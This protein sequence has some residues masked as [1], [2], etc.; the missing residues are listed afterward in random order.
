MGKGWSLLQQVDALT[1]GVR[2][3]AED[4]VQTPCQVLG[5]G[6]GRAVRVPGEQRVADRQVLPDGDLHPLQVQ[7][8]EVAQ[9]L[10]VRPQLGDDPPQV[11]V[12]GRA[13]DRP[14]EAVGQLVERPGPRR[15]RFLVEGAGERL[16]H[17]G[18]LLVQVGVGGG[19]LGGLP[20]G[21]W[22]QQRAELEQVAHAAG[23]H[24]RDPRP[25]PRHQV[26]QALGGQ[27][28]QRLPHRRARGARAGHEG[29]LRQ[30]RAGGQLAELDLRP[31]LPVHHVGLAGLLRER[32][33]RHARAP[34]GNGTPVRSP[35]SR[36]SVSAPRARTTPPA[37]RWAASARSSTSP[38]VKTSSK[39]WARGTDR[40]SSTSCR[41]RASYPAGSPKA[42]GS[43]AR[44]RWPAPLRASGS[45]GPWTPVPTALPVSAPDRTSIMNAI[46]YPLWPAI[47]STTPSTPSAGSVVGA[48]SAVSAHDSGMDSPRL[49]A[50]WILPRATA[51]FAMSRAITRPSGPVAAMDHGLVPSR[52]SRPPHGAM[53]G[54]ALVV[55]TAT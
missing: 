30:R 39:P 48:P 1:G 7:V 51:V 29:E 25:L 38:G 55:R 16:A 43:S 45:Y 5:E 19:G 21:R 11:L 12:P 3:V 40:T 2:Q 27:P 14:V 36:S 47:G 53:A 44:N 34:A 9:P 49:R 18:E 32:A 52:F 54:L 46:A 17:R 20:H 8:G 13:D 50:R 26:D 33:G 23:R 42:A 4:R 35:R 22:L 15:R 41:T 31:E 24:P 10:C 37:A 28:A 6:G